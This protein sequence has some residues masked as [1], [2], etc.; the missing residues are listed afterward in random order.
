MAKLKRL[1]ISTVKR[2]AI[3]RG[4]MTSA[5]WNDTFAELAAD[6]GN[7]S[8][9]WN[10]SL[11]TLLA[12]VPDG[13][14]DVAVDAFKFGLDGSHVYI[15]ADATD[16]AA[17]VRYFNTSKDRPNTIKEQID[18][19]Y[20]QL[21]A[22]ETDIEN[23]DISTGGLTTEQKSR[24]GM[25][26]FD[27]TQTSASTSLDAITNNNKLNLQQV[28][29]DLYGSGW[30]L[31]NDA[32]ANLDNSVKDMVNALLVLHSGSWSGDINLFHDFDATPI[33]K[34]V[35]NNGS[36]AADQTITVLDSKGGKPIIKGSKVSGDHTGSTGYSF[37]SGDS[38]T[39]HLVKFQGVN[40]TAFDAGSGFSQSFKQVLIQASGM[41]GPHQPLQLHVED[42][43][44]AS[45]PGIGLGITT[46]YVAKWQTG[47]ANKALGE[48]GIVL[49]DTTAS[50]L[51]AAHTVAT[52]SK[53]ADPIPSW[54]NGAALTVTAKYRS[55]TANTETA[56]GVPLP[57]STAYRAG[58]SVK[59]KFIGTTNAENTMASEVI[60]VYSS[61]SGDT[62]VSAGP[63]V[64]YKVG[65]GT[66]ATDWTATL[67]L[68]GN[69]VYANVAGAANTEWR[70]VFELLGSRAT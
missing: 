26:I 39:S 9:Q 24:I 54:D 53:P 31:D 67:S 62:T 46:G 18:D 66:T 16:A 5:Q 20:T 43:S 2:N 56:A 58:F 41:S 1:D 35:Y 44:A 60:L 70:I 7:I 37:E 59:A 10:N 19:V 12:T 38:T 15:D 28:A 30:S 51:M 23:F 48:D 69:T 13:T 32:N 65:T 21:T 61:K 14:D 49:I 50:G 11:L 45:D 3:K 8:T 29:K 40:N 27:T 17:T 36:S 33:L 6:L 64:L 52:R 57:T 34:D 68:G 63:M 25:N 42:Y 55:I 47:S 22:L 4:V